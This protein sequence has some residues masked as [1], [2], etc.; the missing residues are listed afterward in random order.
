MKDPGYVYILTNPS[1]RDEIVKIGLTTGTVE[2]DTVRE[3]CFH[4]NK[5]VRGSR[6]VYASLPL[7]LVRR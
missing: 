4:Q 5:K 2:N 6:E 3:I 1:F 7:S